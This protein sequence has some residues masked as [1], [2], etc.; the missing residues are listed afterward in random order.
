MIHLALYGRLPYINSLFYPFIDPITG[1]PIID[2]G[3]MAQLDPNTKYDVKE[4]EVYDPLKYESFEN[5]IFEN[6]KQMDKNSYIIDDYNN[7]AN[8][9]IYYQSLY[10]MY[11]QLSD[12]YKKAQET[13]PVHDHTK[14]HTPYVLF[15]TGILDS[16][17]Q[18]INTL[19]DP[20]NLS[21]FLNPVIEEQK[22]EG[23]ESNFDFSKIDYNRYIDN[24]YNVKKGGK[25]GRRDYE[26]NAI[27]ENVNLFYDT[28]YKELQTEFIQPS[29]NINI[30]MPVDL[31]V[32]D[33]DDGFKEPLIK[34]ERKKKS[35]FDQV[36]PNLIQN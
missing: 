31:P 36:D 3:I 22:T 13:H 8:Y 27:N 35:R 16:D 33:K 6:S 7:P 2:P 30:E 20:N 28:F 21:A 15:N 18:E 25:Q 32:V 26:K 12:Y 34:P 14:P 19:Y 17:Q 9:D 29:E 1:L 5:T 23:D 4:V 24:I 11:P 10:Q